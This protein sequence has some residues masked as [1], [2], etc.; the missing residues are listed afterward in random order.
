MSPYLQLL[1]RL[2][3]YWETDIFWRVTNGSFEI[4]WGDGVVV[5]VALL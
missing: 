4:G 5:R 3:L 1:G 2:E